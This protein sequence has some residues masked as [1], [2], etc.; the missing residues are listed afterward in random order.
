MVKGRCKTNLDNFKFHEWPTVFSEV[1]RIG[2]RV[3]SS[4]TGN[5]LRVVSI[6]HFEWVRD[7]GDKE[8][9][10]IVELNK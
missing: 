2:D 7:N 8:P 6:T 10:I 9:Q 1:P 3:L 4:S 5:V